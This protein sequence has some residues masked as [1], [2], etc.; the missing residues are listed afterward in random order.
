MYALKNATLMTIT[1]GTIEHGT[2]LIENGKITALGTDI[3]IPDGATVFDVDGKTVTPGFIDPHCHT[4]LFADGIGWEHSDGN[5]MTDPITPHMRALDALN[6]DDMA[7]PELVEAGVTTVLTGPGSA[8]LI[9]GTWI[10]VK[11]QP[12]PNVADMILLEPAGM[13][14]ALGENPRR[15]YGS[16]KRMPSTRMGNAAVLRNALFEA[17]NFI[18]KQEKYEA[19]LAEYEQKKA[20]GDEEA[21]EPT[22]LDRNLKMEALVPVLKGE[23]TARI[24]AHRADDILTAIRISEEFGL[25]F[26]IEHCTEGHKIADILAEKNV[27][28]TCGP[29]LISRPKFEMR[30]Q[31]PKNPAILHKAGVKVAI[32]TD[33]M[34]AVK[35]LPINAAL[36]ARYGMPKEEALK[37]ITINAAEIIGVADRI[38]SL[39]VGKD[40]DL[41]VLPGHPLDFMSTPELVFIDGEL[42][43]EKQEA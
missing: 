17:Q 23:L 34:S 25:K 6:P 42:V 1:N 32:Q 20:N 31:T 33:E 7:W 11:T 18:R 13:K 36:A 28:V 22:P 9:G 10:C 29:A 4:G 19:D 38:G 37:A 14:M 26:T 3:P 8:N 2:L 15:V 5:E 12:K 24:H 21:K 35:F 27:P 43:Y 40:A 41:L 39:E 30:G 16:Q